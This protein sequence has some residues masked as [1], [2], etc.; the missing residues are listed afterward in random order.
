MD[1]LCIFAYK[2]YN[3][4]LFLVLGKNYVSIKDAVCS[5]IYILEQ[6]VDFYELL[7]NITDDY[8]EVV[9]AFIASRVCGV[10]KDIHRNHHFSFISPCIKIIPKAFRNVH[11][12]QSLMSSI[13]IF[14]SNMLIKVII[15][16]LYLE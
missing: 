12:L 4:F 9:D 13:Y 5:K 15:F 14:N 3:N 2:N 11:R 6:V 16:W 7:Q 8:Y 10:K 1:N